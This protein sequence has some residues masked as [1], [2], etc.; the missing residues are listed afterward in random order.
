MAETTDDRLRPEVWLPIDGFDYPYE[1]SNLGRVRNAA[2]GHVLRPGLNRGYAHV[3]LSLE[4][5]GK[6]VYIHRLVLLTF[7]GPAHHEGS[8][9]CHNNGVRSDNRLTNLRWGNAAENAADRQRHGTQQFGTKVRTTKLTE[10]AVLQM[11]RAVRGGRSTYSIAKE[12]GLSTH[13]VWCAVVGKTWRNVPE[14]VNNV[15]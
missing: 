9:A 11:R 6:T 13:T 14:A 12:Q 4:G 15:G 2:S 1:V 8:Q 10:D 5:K 7:L 3:S